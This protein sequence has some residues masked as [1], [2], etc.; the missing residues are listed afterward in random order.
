MVR[1]LLIV[2]AFWL[3]VDD[4]FAVPCNSFAPADPLGDDEY[5]SVMPDAA[6]T[7]LTFSR[8][9][10]FSVPSHR[11]LLTVPVPQN[12]ALSGRCTFPPLL[13]LLQHL[14]I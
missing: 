1:W 2:L 8:S 7:R 4:N 11:D 5:L 14:R 12:V 9:I 10:V 3:V 6:Q 13:Y